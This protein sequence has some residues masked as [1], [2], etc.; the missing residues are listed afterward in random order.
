[1]GSTCMIKISKILKPNLS[2]NL[3]GI[4]AGA[5]LFGHLLPD[6]VQSGLYA[7]SLS[8]K[9]ILL[10]ALPL[11]IFS[12]LFSCLLGF[13]GKAIGFMVA[14]FG[15]VCLSNYLSTLFAYGVGSLGLIRLESFTTD[16][17]KQALD[18]L[19]LWQFTL[20]K[21][22]L[23]DHAL[24]LGFILGTYFSLRPAAFADK[25][26][27]I[28]KQIVTVF[29]KKGFIP[30]LPLFAL[31]F[32]LKMQHDGLL[33]QI[34]QSYLPLLLVIF[35]AYVAYLALLF[36]LAANFKFERWIFYI[37]N[38]LPA[39]MMGFSTMSSM[40]AMPVTLTAAE[41]N[42]NSPDIANVVIPTTV[43]IHLLGDCIA[44]PLMAIA[45]MASF[46]FEFPS[47]ATFGV[48]ALYVVLA[49]FAAAAVPGGGILVVLPILETHLGFTGEMS[50]LITTLY[51][52]FDPV[53][54]VTNVLGNN[55]LVIL[56]TKL[57][58]KMSGIKI[59]KVQ[60]DN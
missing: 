44:I 32:V 10:F 42:T 41:K 39:G 38:A 51:I 18:L 46:G 35:L 55:A 45:I 24:Y 25:L 52:L 7:I 4:L 19:P 14:I 54:T 48:F 5:L 28:L 33:T 50:A 20:P 22:I 57:Y 60:E 9:E 59:T 47:F 36:A 2:L 49:R 15:I 26:G 13:R 3:L 29:L 56:L 1:M 58:R 21:W 30:V 37:K 23:N 11:V 6:T 8:L 40:A 43:N 17:A 12:C 27:N 53:I 34:V 16:T 31:G